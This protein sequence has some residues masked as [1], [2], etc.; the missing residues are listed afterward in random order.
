MSTTAQAP[1]E[2]MLAAKPVGRRLLTGLRPTGRL[3]LGNYVG[4]L[5]EDLRLQADPNY[6]CFFL[7]ADFHALTTNVERAA[8]VAQNARETL[9]DMLASGIDPEKSTLY[10]QSTIPEVSEL[11]LLLTM[12]V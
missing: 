2:P 3:H 4:T 12:L 9:L 1:G 10:V 6:T 7:V 8:E 5:E 11:F